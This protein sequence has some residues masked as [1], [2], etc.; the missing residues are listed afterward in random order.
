MNN[1]YILLHRKIVDWEWYSDINVLALFIHCLFLANWEDKK[2]RGIEI[3]R[4]QFFTSTDH[5]AK[6]LCLS[7]MQIRTALTKLKSTN[8]ITVEAT[9]KGTKI[10]ICKYN[11]YQDCKKRN[12]KPI[13]SEVTSEQQTDNKPITTT[14]EYNT[15]KEEK[16]DIEQRKTDFL[17]LLKQ[18]FPTENERRLDAFFKYWSEY[19]PGAKKMRWEKQD[20][21]DL[22]RRMG[23]WKKNEKDGEYGENKTTATNRP[24]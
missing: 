10:T 4:G 19:S 13:T 15:L 3:K 17:L 5:L 23:T 9:S 20:A 14:K 7:A 16:K 21:F 1:G 24:M 11:D 22:G 2:W 8:E 6:S 12:N 18:T